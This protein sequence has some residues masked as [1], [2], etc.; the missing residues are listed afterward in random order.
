[1]LHVAFALTGIAAAGGIAFGLVT[2]LDGDE[3]AASCS[4][5]VAEYEEL[6]ANLDGQLV[7]ETGAA[8]DTSVTT[9]ARQLGIPREDGSTTVLEVPPPITEA[10]L[11]ELGLC[12][13][14]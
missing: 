11:A 12:N 13:Q 2:A 3:S 9:V 1:V 7:S 14:Q 4:Q 8:A 10:R 5:A 6:L